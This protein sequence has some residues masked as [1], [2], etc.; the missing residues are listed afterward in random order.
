M[1]HLNFHPMDPRL[2]A[3]GALTR[4]AYRGDNE[5]SGDMRTAIDYYCK[6]YNTDR[7]RFSAMLDVYEHVK[8][9]LVCEEQEL[10][11]LFGF[12][13][14]LETNLY[15]LVRQMQFNLGDEKVHDLNLRI[16][17][18][19]SDEAIDVA[20]GTV[21]ITDLLAYT[22]GLPIADPSKLL[23]ADA[24]IRF[25]EYESRVNRL[26]DQAEA[27]IREKADL[28]A[29]YA[30]KALA[31]WNALQDE[32]AFFDQLA[33][34]GIRLDC[35]QADVTP[36]V[37]QFTTIYLHSNILTAQ[38]LGKEEHTDI[39]YG[40][41]VD[42]FTRTERTGKTDLESVANLLHALDDKK[43]LQILVALRE[44]PLYG[45]ELATITELSPGTVS[46]H[47]SELVGSGL[48]TIEKQ[49]VKLLYSLNESRIKEFTAMLEKS[50]LR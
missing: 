46:H 27:L 8:A 42:E 32:A 34:E 5:R 17:L 11:A 16:A 25:D 26:L 4:L 36:I 41:L 9:N 6:K 48:V 3:A 18:A 45:Q 23:F 20:F 35:P 49:G 15:D 13:D 29:P 40:V 38:Y 39:L 7:S 30:E 43:R 1:Q 47:M 19:V 12:P 31:D 28:L 33:I 44:R 14:G 21:G 10:V 2:E 22:Q 37:M 50:F 24:V